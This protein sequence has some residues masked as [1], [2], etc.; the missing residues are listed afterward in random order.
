MSRRVAVVGAG[1]G[2]LAVAFELLQRAEQLP[3]GPVESFT[4]VTVQANDLV[5]EYHPKARM[6]AILDRSMFAAWLDP[7]SPMD[8]VRALLTSYPDEAMAARAA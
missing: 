6:P 3:D 1:I 5:T 4:I 7:A 8:D 2:G